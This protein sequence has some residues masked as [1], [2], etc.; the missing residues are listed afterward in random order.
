[1][2]QKTECPQVTKNWAAHV[3]SGKRFANFLCALPGYYPRIYAGK[4]RLVFMQN[5][6]Q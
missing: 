1:M 6:G 2:T 5:A 3:L 4:L